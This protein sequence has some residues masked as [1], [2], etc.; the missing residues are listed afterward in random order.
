[1]EKTLLQTRLEKIVHTSKLYALR[2]YFF[3]L[4]V[5]HCLTAKRLKPKPRTIRHQFL[6][7]NNCAAMQHACSKHL[8]HSLIVLFIFNKCASLQNISGQSLIQSVIGFSI[9]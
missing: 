9:A 6:Y 3:K 4:N 2:A 1:M 7:Y 8:L 5:P